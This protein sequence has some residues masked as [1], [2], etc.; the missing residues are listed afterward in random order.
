[1]VCLVFVERSEVHDSMTPSGAPSKRRIGGH[2]GAALGVR[3]L[4]GIRR[5]RWWVGSLRKSWSKGTIIHLPGSLQQMGVSKNNGT[6]KSSILIGFSTI[7]H[8]FRVPLFL[9]TPKSADT[10]QC[11]TPKIFRA[12]NHWEDSSWIEETWWEKKWFQWCV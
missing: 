8:P 9:E 7:N 2:F 11:T 12:K 1:M 10:W 5:T 3:N 4:G 6:P